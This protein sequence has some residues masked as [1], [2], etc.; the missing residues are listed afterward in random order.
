MGSTY[1]GFP[2]RIASCQM[3]STE[4]ARETTADLLQYDS[5]IP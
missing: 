5:V 2:R 4:V 1:N 3:E